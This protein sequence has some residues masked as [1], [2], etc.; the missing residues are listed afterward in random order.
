MADFLTR[1][2]ERS[3]DLAP[4]DERVEP[5]IAPFF[6]AGP[7]TAPGDTMPGDV[8]NDVDEGLA[9]VAQ[10]NAQRLAPAPR[11]AEAATRKA[12]NISIA[13]S[14]QGRESKAGVTLGI[15]PARAL[16][17]ETQNARFNQTSHIEPLP[18]TP[19]STLPPAPLVNA[20]PGLTDPADQSRRANREH[21]AIRPQVARADESSSRANE[22]ANETA[23]EKT[24]DQA[25]PIIRVTIGRVDVRAVSQTAPSARRPT[26]PAAPKLSLEEYLRQRGGGKR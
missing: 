14:P 4:R 3:R 2:I 8:M 26:T 24:G 10:S 11:I 7:N 12:E 21:F 16:M 9:S 1:L 15:N 20:R 19:K 25:A 17:D 13:P 6:A 18:P 5:L 22:A 23:N